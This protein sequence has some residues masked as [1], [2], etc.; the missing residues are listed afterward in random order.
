MYFFPHTLQN[1]YDNHFPTTPYEKTNPPS[2]PQVFAIGVGHEGCLDVNE[3]NAL[4]NNPDQRY[5]FIMPNSTTL[6]MV[7]DS[8]LTTLCSA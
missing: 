7:T 8:I 4:A 6:P 2:A 3:I 5:G 1:I